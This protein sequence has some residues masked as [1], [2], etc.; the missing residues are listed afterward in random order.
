MA[1]LDKTVA[2]EMA[3]MQ[4]HWCGVLSLG[5]VLLILGLIGLG[6]EFMLT[7]VSMYFFAV[8]LI[9]SGLSH[10]LDAFK[11]KQLKA[12]VWQILIAVLYVCGGIIVI[13]DPLLASALFTAL[14]AW[15]LIIIGISR[16]FMAFFIKGSSGWGWVLLAGITSFILGLL[17]LMQ[18]P[19][20]GLW[21]IGMFI[22]IELIVSGWTYILMALSL[23]CS[24]K[25]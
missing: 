4:R 11:Y 3:L 21:V 5:I 14:L 15:V 1:Q 13:Y 16:L 18:W 10:F 12:S 7:V 9:V 22:A 17:I 25:A 6:M 2:P 24:L 23:R 8:L 20:S 19:V